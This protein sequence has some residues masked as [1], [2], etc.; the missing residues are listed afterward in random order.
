MWSLVVNPPPLTSSCILGDSPGCEEGKPALFQVPWQVLPWGCNGGADP[1]CHTAALL[2]AGEGGDPKRR[3]L[4]PPWD[5]GAPGLLRRAGQVRRL[6]QGGAHVGL[7]EQWKPAPSEVGL[8]LL[9]LSCRHIYLAVDVSAP[10]DA[11]LCPMFLEYW[12]STN[13]TKSSGR[14]GFKCGM[15]NTRAWWGDSHLLQ[16][17]LL[18]E[19][20]LHIFSTLLCLWLIKTFL[21]KWF[22]FFYL[23]C[24]TFDWSLIA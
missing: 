12:I 13:S 21:P 11:R 8:L 14:R 16:L 2:P 5:G 1:G 4:L 9:F 17:L 18:N 19:V 6:Q 23:Y 3:H 15:K 24:L 22:F 7:P 20:L 10:N